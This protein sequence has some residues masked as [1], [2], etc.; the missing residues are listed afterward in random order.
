MLG[1]GVDAATLVVALGACPPPP[2][3]RWGRRPHHGATARRLLERD[4]RGVDGLGVEDDRTGYSHLP[5]TGGR[6]IGRC[7]RAA[8]PA[9]TVLLSPADA[10]LCSHLV[11]TCS[12]RLF[13]PPTHR[14]PSARVTPTSYAHCADSATIACWSTLA[15]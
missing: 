10:H 5:F 4:H 13:T 6:A 3:C 15:T 9:Q 11:K 2:E 7:L 12:H 14:L 1:G 8:L